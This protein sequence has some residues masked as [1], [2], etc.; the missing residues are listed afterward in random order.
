[1]TQKMLVTMSTCIMQEQKMN[2]RRG[3][4]SNRY[5]LSLKQPVSYTP[6]LIIAHFAKAVFFMSIFYAGKFAFVQ[7]LLCLI[8]K[9]F[10]HCFF[11]ISRIK[12]WFDMIIVAKLSRV[13]VL[14]SQCVRNLKMFYFVQCLNKKVSRY[15]SSSCCRCVTVYCSLWVYCLQSFFFNIMA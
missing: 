12:N 4:I 8:L 3:Q 15:F 2:L 11:L 6:L 14:T 10:F 5:K 1:M 7:R 13:S 9:D